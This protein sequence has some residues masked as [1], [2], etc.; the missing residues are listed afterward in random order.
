MPESQTSG[1][2]AR[3]AGLRFIREMIA[4]DFK[5]GGRRGKIFSLGLV[6]FATVSLSLRG[7]QPAELVDGT[8]ALYRGNYQRAVSLAQSYMKAHPKVAA[9]Y[10]LLARAEIAE[11]KYLSAYRELLS[12]LRMDPK[13]V[14][15]LYYLGRVSLVLSQIQYQQLYSPG[16]ES[17]RVHQVLAESYLSQE[18]KSRS[19]ERRV[20]KECRSRWS[21]YH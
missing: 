15:A 7:E 6:M 4:G 2:R 14:D 19:E 5:E 9:A 17:L 1:R 8:R 10:L 18:N 3:G 21:P 16:P 11:G 12:A 20:G 13:N